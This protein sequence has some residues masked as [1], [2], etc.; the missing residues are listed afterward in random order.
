[1]N[2][3]TLRNYLYDHIP[4]TKAMQVEIVSV[5]DASL[6]Q[7]APL[8]PNINHRETVFGGSASA[9]CILSA[10]AF[11]RCRLKNYPQFTPR[12]VIQRNTMEYS[13]PILD[14]FQ[15]TCTLDSST[16]WGRLIKSLERKAIGRIQL[17]S[18]L[19]CNGEPA[20]KFE[21]SFVISDRAS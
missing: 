14:Q 10:W 7:T 4:L 20:G 21:G 5:S 13:K 2:H 6:T 19:T 15:A 8:A 11:I 18:S 12:I 9:L 3:D 1:M 16:R 17:T